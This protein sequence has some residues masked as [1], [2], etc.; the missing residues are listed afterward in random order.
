VYTNR[1]SIVVL[2]RE[3]EEHGETVGNDERGH[4]NPE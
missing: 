1:K 2:R 3:R 4:G